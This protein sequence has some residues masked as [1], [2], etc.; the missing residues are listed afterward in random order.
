[1]H[2]DD[3]PPHPT[4]LE[5]AE[6]WAGQ[7][8]SIPLHVDTKHPKYRLH[9]QLCGT[10]LRAEYAIAGREPCL[11]NPKDAAQRGV[12]DGDVSGYSMTAGR[13]WPA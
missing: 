9:S 10:K 7:P 6:R 1:M 12:A 3:C 8:R 13:S 11:M 4:W 2:Y 5:P